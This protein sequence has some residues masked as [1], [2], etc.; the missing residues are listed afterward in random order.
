M[1]GIVVD[2]QRKWHHVQEVRH[3]QVEHVDV[4]TRQVGTQPPYLQDDGWVQRQADEEDEAVDGREKD[5]LEVLLVGT[6]RAARP[7]D[8]AVHQGQALERG[9]LCGLQVQTQVEAGEG[10]E[11][12]EGG[13]RR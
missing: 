9:G 1:A 8:I 11:T 7:A 6:L 2:Q 4:V 13:L 3:G 10:K 12:Q 5:A